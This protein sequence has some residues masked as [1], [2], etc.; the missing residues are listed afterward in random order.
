MKRSFSNCFLSHFTGA[1]VG[2]GTLGIIVGNID[3]DE[4]SKG[5]TI[6][7]VILFYLFL[8]VT[9]LL[10]AATHSDRK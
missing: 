2:S 5:Q 6:L 1:I 8:I 9:S 10:H 3:L 7:L 4:L